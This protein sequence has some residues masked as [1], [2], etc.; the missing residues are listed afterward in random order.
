MLVYGPFEVESYDSGTLWY[1]KYIFSCPSDPKSKVLCHA[2]L[3]FRRP[4]GTVTQ[5]V[6]SHP[7][8][9]LR[10]ETTDFGTLR[11]EFGWFE[12]TNFN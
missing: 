2:K 1:T 12:K 3:T 5:N 10:P 4:Y 11:V 7:F 9:A 8:G 6:Y